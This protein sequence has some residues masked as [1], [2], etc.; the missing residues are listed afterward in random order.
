MD[1][2]T[3]WEWLLGAGATGIAW[4]NQTMYSNQRQIERDLADHKK[5][6]A[7]KYARNEDITRLD[8]KL[9]RILERL[10]PKQ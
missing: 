1:S 6:T 9:D 10:P 8:D 5:E 4:W 2:P 3:L 7:E